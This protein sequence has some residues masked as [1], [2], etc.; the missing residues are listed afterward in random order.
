[1][2]I[3]IVFLMM[4]MFCAPLTG[5]AMLGDSFAQAERSGRVVVNGR[6]MPT[7]PGPGKVWDGGQGWQSRMVRVNPYP[8][9]YG[10]RDYVYYRWLEP[11]KDLPVEQGTLEFWIQ[12]QNDSPDGGTSDNLLELF[13]AAGE[14]LLTIAVAWVDP[15]ATGVI[16]IWKAKGVWEDNTPLPAVEVGE[17]LHL[18]FTW[19]PDGARD[20]KVYA[21]GAEVSAPLS[22]GGGSLAEIM[23]RTRS[24][25]LGLGASDTDPACHTVIDEFRFSDIIKRS[26]DLRRSLFPMTGEPR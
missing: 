26:F 21:N 10:R 24:L 20:N 7:P 25:R 19:G 5:W 12:R 1:M 13:D 2:W 8:D 11:G 17:W 18:G 16:N 9:F 23:R 4:A 15:P 6:F 22:Q 14:T 3:S